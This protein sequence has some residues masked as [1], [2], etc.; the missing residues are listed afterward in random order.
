MANI[1]QYKYL[2]YLL[3][4]TYSIQV[5][6]QNSS[7]LT[8]EKIMQGEKFIGVSPSNAY[9]SES[10]S[11]IYF[12][13]NPA[14]NLGDSLYA[15]SLATHKTTKVSPQ[16]RRK[17]PAQHGIYN[18]EHTIKLYEKNGD[19]FLYFIKS[20]DTKQITNTI[21]R[22]SN[23]SFS[24][25]EKNIIFQTNSNLFSLNI[26]NGNFTQLTNFTTGSKQDKR[27]IP[28]AENEKFLY[29]DQLTYF[30]ILKERKEKKA[31]KKQFRKK[32]KTK[33]PKTI[34]LGSKSIDNIILSPDGKFVT[35]RLTKRANPE[36]TKVPNYV[37]EHGNTENLVTRPNVGRAQTTYET[38]IYDIGNDTTFLLKT[39][40]I[41]GI[42]DIPDFLKGKN[43]GKSLF[44]KERQSI[45]HGPI[46]SDNGKQAII[47]VR[48]IDNKDRWIMLL[49]LATG[50]PKLL[51]RQTDQAWIGGPGISS[52]NYT[53]GAIGW[54]PDNKT[55]WLQSEESG[56]SHLCSINVNTGKKKTLTKG[57]FEIYNPQLSKDKQYFYFSSN[58][59]HPGERHFYKMSINGGKRTK[60]TKAAGR[61]DVILSPDETKMAI[62]Q[63]F[64][65][66]PTELYITANNIDNKPIKIT[67]SQT[68]DFKA[69]TWRTP[70]FI[71]F[72][73]SDGADVYAR[74]YQPETSKKTSAA[75]IFVHGAGYLQNA[76][77]WWSSYYHE[78]M[79]HNFLADNGYTILD[80]D[81]RG[82]AGYGRDWRTGIYR[83][84]GGKDLDDQ[85]DGAKLLVEKYNIDKNKIGIYGGS[86]GGFITIMAQFTKPGIFKAGAALRSVTDWAHYNHEYTSNILNTPVQD[87]I[88]YAKSS[89]IY[90]AEG[91]QDALLMCHGVID[92]NVHFQDVVRL[93]QRL[94]ELGKDDWELAIYPLEGHGF[95]E[96][97]SWTDEY[98]RIF[99]LFE[100]NLK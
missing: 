42:Y 89:P 94:I 46:W 64:A 37:T 93:S 44:E 7:K 69:Y 92:T 75:V 98:K 28:S 12:R 27:D 84:M 19:I 9:W 72:K 39:G 62:L 16:K 15:Y 86:Y 50:K 68:D 43:D 1:K 38:E 13:W 53:T 91:L 67:D 8:I 29:N 63:S 65:N 35:Y 47:V 73:A 100:K 70:A 58:E 31:A 30:E 40:M 45:V 49:D 41:P 25:D 22:E 85:I 61:N 76:H 56:Y 24:Q 54:L 20:E 11:E 57:K 32:N 88:A 60:I 95:K 74:I 82:S 90:Y 33:R 78:Y 99:K 21:N 52:W 17:L 51:D 59:V 2:V 5:Y 26:A 97:S 83:F 34:Y 4:L 96:P 10:G 6:A 23:L 79:F 55:I 48:S 18:H 81:Y 36:N 71:S 80:I 77:K 66:Q 87:S 3:L 14:G